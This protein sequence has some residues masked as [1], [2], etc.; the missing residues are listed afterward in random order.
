M[1]NQEDT[2][3]V[4]HFS[5]EV[6]PPLSSNNDFSPLTTF[7]RLGESAFNHDALGDFPIDWL[8]LLQ[9]DMGLSEAGFRNLL[10]HRHEMQE[11]AYLEEVEKKPVRVLKSKYDLEKEALV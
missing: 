3:T 1:P 2:P 11:E 10:S 8:K 4:P 9:S 5:L 6:P 7:N